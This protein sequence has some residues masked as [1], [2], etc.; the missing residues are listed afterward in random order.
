[1]LLNTLKKLN[2][3]VNNLIIYNIFICKLKLKTKT[4]KKIFEYRDKQRIYILNKTK[5]MAFQYQQY[6][7]FEWKSEIYVVLLIRLQNDVY[8]DDVEVNVFHPLKQ[9]SSSLDG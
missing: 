6:P 5:L 4:N 8:V 3:I 9:H 1:M 2:S 7:S